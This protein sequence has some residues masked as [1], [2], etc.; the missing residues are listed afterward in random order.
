MLD[1]VAECGR[2]LGLSIAW[3]ASGGA[4]DGNNLAAEGLPTVDS[5]G[6]RG[7]NLHSSEEY[8]FIDSITERALLTALLL[9]KLA[10]GELKVE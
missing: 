1:H 6:V 10:S 4:C 2:D 7:G 8:V 3:R 5:M 9:M